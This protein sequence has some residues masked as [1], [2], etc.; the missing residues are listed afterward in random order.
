MIFV[1]SVSEAAWM[2]ELRLFLILCLGSWEP[3][4]GLSVLSVLLN[5]HLLLYVV[6]L[7]MLSV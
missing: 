7:I 2:T 5:Y 6:Q 4:C 1:D 3:D